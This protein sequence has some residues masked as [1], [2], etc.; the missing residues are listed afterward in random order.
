MNTL[1]GKKS[2][3]TS[4]ITIKIKFHIGPTCRWQR[5]E[6]SHASGSL[7]SY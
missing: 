1:T 7:V 6:S 5:L 2:L 4:R 3:F